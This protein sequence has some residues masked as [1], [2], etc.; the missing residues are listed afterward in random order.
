MEVVG[1][2][3]VLD[4]AAVFRLVLGHNAVGAVVDSLHQMHWFALPHVFATVG[5]NDVVWNAQADCAIN[6][7]LSAL[8]VGVEG[9]DVIAKK[10]SATRAGVGDERF[11]VA[12]FQLEVVMEVVGKLV[13]DGLRFGFGTSKSDQPIISVANVPQAAEVGIVGVARGNGLRLLVVVA[14]GFPVPLL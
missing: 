11:G 1:Q 13:L 7:T 14:C 5:W 6:A 3:V 2:A 12:Q 4:D 10:S 8:V 9:V